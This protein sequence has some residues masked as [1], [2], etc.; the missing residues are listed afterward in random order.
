MRGN[1]IPVPLEE[2]MRDQVN[3]RAQMWS[4]GDIPPHL[5]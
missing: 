4:L 1:N 5:I 3:V 2:L